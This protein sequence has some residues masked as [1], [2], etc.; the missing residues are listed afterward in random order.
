M[1]R[2]P[3]AADLHRLH[4]HSVPDQ[5]SVPPG[6]AWRL[7]LPGQLTDRPVGADPRE[8]ERHGWSR[9]EARPGEKETEIGRPVRG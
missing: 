1:V 2:S 6:Q 3:A 9:Q 4:G 8:S 5:L 7:N